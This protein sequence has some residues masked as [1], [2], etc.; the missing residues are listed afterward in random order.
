MPSRLILRLLVIFT[1]KLEILVTT[2]AF[3]LQHNIPEIFPVFMALPV[4]LQCCVVPH[5]NKIQDT[6][7]NLKTTN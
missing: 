7:V 2:L 5:H 3:F 6:R 1:R 4:W